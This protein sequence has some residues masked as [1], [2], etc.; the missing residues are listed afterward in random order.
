MQ[1]GAG[2]G[3][4]GKVESNLRLSC[5]RVLSQ[6]EFHVYCYTH[7]QWF[8]GLGLYIPGISLKKDS[9]VQ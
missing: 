6:W 1:T 8:A 3:D 2:V 9:W 4:W 7:L 5:F